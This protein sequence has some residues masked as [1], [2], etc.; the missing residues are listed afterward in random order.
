MHFYH[1]DEST[2]PIINSIVHA[3]KTTYVLSLGQMEN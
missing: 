3:Y 2:F 1:I